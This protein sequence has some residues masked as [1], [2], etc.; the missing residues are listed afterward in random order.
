[1]KILQILPRLKSGGVERGTLEIVRA[2][3]AAGVPN[4]V[5][6]AG[7]PLVAKLDALGV[8]HHTLPAASKNPFIVF[9]NARRLAALIRREGYTLIHARSR[10]PAWS[11]WLAAR[12]TG[13][14]YLATYHGVHGTSP[15]WLK[16]PYNRVLLK[17]EKVVAVSDFVK[18]H[19]MDAY[20]WPAERIVRIF[21]GADTAVFTP[22]AETAARG[23]AL[24]KTLGFAPDLPVVTLP[25]RLTR[26][27]GQDVLLDALAHVSCPA[28]GCLLVGSDQG[29]TAYTA[30][31]HARAARLPAHVRVAFLDH[32]D[33]MPAVYAMSEIVVSATHGH[34]EAF[35]RTIPEAQAMGV[36]TVGTAL[37]GACETIQDGRTGLLVPPGDAGALADALDRL[38]A[39]PGP[40]KAAMRAAARAS[41]EQF[42]STER[43]CD[44]TLALYRALQR[45]ARA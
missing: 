38:L 1:M 19:L 26:L 12:W 39:L 41:V 20:G 29:Q 9:Q 40:D 15:A 45:P 35:G 16:K 22:T 21:R 25:A 13:I 14:P 32:T 17:G 4:G 37:G 5:V 33:D 23:A 43:M 8:P 34:P 6:S 3:V 44:E 7:G 24:K 10:A 31:L 11:A 36:L 27:K 42:F 30:H 2:L 18:R 28:V